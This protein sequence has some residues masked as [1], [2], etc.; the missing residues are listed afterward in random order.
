[1]SAERS[2]TGVEAQSALY[3]SVLA[4]KRVLVLLDNARDADQVRPLLPGTA[5]CLA[6]VTSRDRLASLVVADGAYPLILDLLTDTEA[7]DLLVHRLGSTRI[8]QEPNAVGEIIDRCAGLPLALAIVAGRAA[9]HPGFSLAA[10]ATELHDPAG[11]LG[12][13][14]SDDRAIDIRAVVSWSYR[15]LSAGAARLFRLSSVHSGADLTAAT[16]A[17]LAG[18]PPR[19]VGQLLAELAR[20]NLFTEHIPGRYTF[21]DLLRAYATERSRREDSADERGAA[22]RRV[23]DHYV[24]TA[25][26]ASRLLY[27]PGVLFTLGTPA[28]G[29]TPQQITGNKEASAWFAAERPTM[30]AAVSQAAAAGLDR[31]VVELAWS[32]TTFFN[33]HGRWLDLR[34]VN[35]A[36]LDAAQRLDD[37]PGQVRAHRLAG[38]GCLGLGDYTAAAAHLQCWMKLLTGTGDLV[39][40]GHV[41]LGMADMY[42]RQG[43]YVAAIRHGQDGLAIFRS[44]DDPVGQACALAAIG[45]CH[46]ESG[47]AGRGVDYCQEALA[48]L[49]DH[50]DLPTEAN[51]LHMLGYAYHQ[52]GIADEA[53][54]AYHKALTLW[55]DIG[56]HYGVALT[57]TNVGDTHHATGDRA[58]ATGAWQQALDI[59]TEMGHRDADAIRAKL[60]TA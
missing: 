34:T 20:S 13:F 40:Q 60:A 37:I 38:R 2:P 3:R 33:Q 36:A 49:R 27:P 16:A 46:A 25:H 41:H 23:L 53:I 50:P 45:E 10:L 26:P 24:H 7:R 54:D 15:T 48:L 51:T 1:L 35:E 52:L 39:G 55:R 28:T 11:A 5:G 58:A 32:L 9:S 14:R 21:H 4:G 43:D 8:E 30:L 59:L 12:P 17:S 44:A 18:T 56:D 42:G 29:V 31:H 57:A 19:L 22:L 6:I 47:D